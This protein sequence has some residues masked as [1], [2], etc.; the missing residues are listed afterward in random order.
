MFDT[1]DITKLDI[2]RLYRYI[3]KY[4]KNIDDCDSLMDEEVDTIFQL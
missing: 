4:I 1:Y 3:D 2:N